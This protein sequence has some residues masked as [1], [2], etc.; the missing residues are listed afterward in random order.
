MTSTEQEIWA[1]VNRFYAGVNQAL[2]GGD[3][4]AVRRAWSHGPEA[5][6]MHPGGGRHLGWNEVDQAWSTWADVVEGG[7][8]APASLAVRLVT[9]DVAVVTGEELG[10]G[11]IAG[12]RV[13]IDARVTLV[14]RREGREWRAVHHHVDVV[15]ALREIVAR[16][17]HAA[18]P[19]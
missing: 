16:L 9:P 4:D 2:D 10:A 12:E 8:I 18:V 6:A 14:L 3:V 17:A 1:A 5:A 15:P 19:G 11:T 7:H 13:E